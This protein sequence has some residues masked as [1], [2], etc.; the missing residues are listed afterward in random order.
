MAFISDLTAVPLTAEE[1]TRELGN[2]GSKLLLD[3]PLGI[4]YD[5]EICQ[6]VVADN[7][8]DRVRS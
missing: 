1:M 3:R 5:E 4:C 7:G 6:W 2:H 8:G